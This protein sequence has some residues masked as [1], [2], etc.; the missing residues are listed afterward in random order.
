MK[1]RLTN[2]GTIS[3]FGGGG[4]AWL[5]WKGPTTLDGT[6]QVVFGTGWSNYLCWVSSDVLTIGSGQQFP[7][8]LKS[9]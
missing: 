1:G 3:I 6:G 2:N 7:V 9:R 8:K 4:N 5:D